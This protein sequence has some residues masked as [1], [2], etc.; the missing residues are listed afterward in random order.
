MKNPEP[1]P[2]SPEPPISCAAVRAELS[3]QLYGEL[4]DA[5]GQQ[6]DRH[7]SGCTSCAARRAQLQTT[8]EMLD[9]W[10]AP[11]LTNTQPRRML[12]RWMVAAAVLAATIG[13]LLFGVQLERDG[14]RIAVSLRT[15][16]KS[17]VASRS[18]ADRERLVSIERQLAALIEGRSQLLHEL[19][20]QSA[21]IETHEAHVS[22]T[23]DELA[24]GMRDALDRELRA[25]NLYLDANERGA[26]R[27]HRLT[28]EALADL[29]HLVVAPAVGG[30]NGR[31]VG[32]RPAR[33]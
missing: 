32:T 27:E 10:D 31:G 25:L 1:L 21:R 19:D 9:A 12:R 20:A 13:L 16:W 8:R 26:E 30:P 2:S 18:T 7:V 6:I 15:P 17:S 5:R 11:Q 23:H 22:R 24:R 29:A 3:L 4:D 33:R 28:R 14:E